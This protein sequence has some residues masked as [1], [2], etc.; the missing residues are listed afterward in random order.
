VS[1]ETRIWKCGKCDRE[2]V[3]KKTVFAYMGNTV[4]HEV[5]A[6][7]KCGKVFIPQ[8]LAEGRM[9]EVE[10]LLECK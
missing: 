3:P 1:P 6:C 4:A 9:A 5:S 7:P 10:E 2:L 8:D